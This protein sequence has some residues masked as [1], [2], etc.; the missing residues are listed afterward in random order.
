MDQKPSIDRW[1]L[2]KKIQTTRDFCDNKNRQ[3]LNK[4]RKSAL[5]LVASRSKFCIFNLS[6]SHDLS[7]KGPYRPDKGPNGFRDLDIQIVTIWRVHTTRDTSTQ[8]TPCI[9]GYAD[10]IGSNVVNFANE[11]LGFRMFQ[12]VTICQSRAVNPYTAWWSSENKHSTS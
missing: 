4:P 5:I 9:A 8:S 12:M 1:W 7:V 11:I 10:F 6:S 3:F 2:F